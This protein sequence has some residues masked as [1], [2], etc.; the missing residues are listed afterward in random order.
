M[1]VEERALF[2][3][4]AGDLAW[5]LPI[6]AALLGSAFDSYGQIDVSAARAWLTRIVVPSDTPHLVELQ[7]RLAK[8]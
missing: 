3:Q 5:H 7:E 4:L 6:F 8:P 2:H 1:G